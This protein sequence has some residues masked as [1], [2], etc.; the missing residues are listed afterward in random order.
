MAGKSL[1]RSSTGLK[2]FVSEYIATR[3]AISMTLGAYVGGPFR[4]F[5]IVREGDAR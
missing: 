4:I 5:R 1:S 2:K 3:A